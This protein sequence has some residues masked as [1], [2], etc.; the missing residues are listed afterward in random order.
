MQSEKDIIEI[1]LLNT[2]MRIRT[3][4]DKDHLNEV[5]KHFE[6]TLNTVADKMKIEDPLKLALIAGIIVTDEYKRNT[7]NSQLS[8]EME[9]EISQQIAELI[10]DLDQCI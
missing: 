6:E 5:I 2:K 8:I 7:T 1:K 9:K 3:S 10:D 4:E